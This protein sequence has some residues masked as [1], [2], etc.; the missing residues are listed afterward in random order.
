VREEKDCAGGE[1][2]G[3]EMD[4]SHSDARIDSVNDPLTDDSSK[5]LNEGYIFQR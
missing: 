3:R 1:G 2:K 4:M 5:Q